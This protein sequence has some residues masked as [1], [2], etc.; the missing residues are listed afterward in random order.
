[1][2]P[3]EKRAHNE[4]IRDDGHGRVDNSLEHAEGACDLGV[5]LSWPVG[6]RFVLR[7]RLH[8]PNNVDDSMLTNKVRQVEGRVRPRF[9]LTIV[10]AAN[11]AVAEM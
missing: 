11:I 5:V 2:Q 1:M 8:D 9:P 10:I 7:I 6:M 3:L 4:Y